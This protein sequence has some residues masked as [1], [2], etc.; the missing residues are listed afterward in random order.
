MLQVAGN[1][2][3]IRFGKRNLVE[4]TIIWVCESFRCLC[5]RGIQAFIADTFDYFS[6]LLRIKFKLV[7]V[8]HFRIFRKNL[9]V[10][11]GDESP[12]K[13]GD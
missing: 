9:V 4:N 1:K 10:M 7:S 5:T 11:Q 3:G 12:L 13:E 6:H 2:V 8:Q